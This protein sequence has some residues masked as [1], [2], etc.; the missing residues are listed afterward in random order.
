MV[1]NYLGR[2]LHS[3][4]RATLG[5]SWVWRLQAS[6]DQRTVGSFI[7][8]S[9]RLFCLDDIWFSDL[10]D[11]YH[12]SRILHSTFW[13]LLCLWYFI[14]YFLLIHIFLPQV[15]AQA[16]ERFQLYGAL[17]AS[18]CQA[19]KMHTCVHVKS[20]KRTYMAYMWLTDR[21]GSLLYVDVTAFEKSKKP[22]CQQSWGITKNLFSDW[23]Q[24]L[25]KWKWSDSDNP[26]TLHLKYTQHCSCHSYGHGNAIKNR[27][28]YIYPGKQ[29]NG[30]RC[31]VS[32]ARLFKKPFILNC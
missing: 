31:G 30:C 20:Y 22:V 1:T 23:D 24:F 21:Q 11:S 8:Y 19:S 5:F 14:L 7:L 15:V 17:A 25:K 9:W 13:R 16:Y 26:T 2:T 18:V 27:F 6:L 10:T 3:W 12:Y 4:I 29:C 32:S 28:I